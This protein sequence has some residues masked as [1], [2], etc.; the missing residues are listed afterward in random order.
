[1]AT[2]PKPFEFR[3]GTNEF[4]IGGVVGRERVDALNRSILYYEC[5]RDFIPLKPGQLEKIV[6]ESWSWWENSHE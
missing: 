4:W 6:L 5:V 1:M 2:K 3:R